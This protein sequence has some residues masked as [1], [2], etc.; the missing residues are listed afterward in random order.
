MDG[1]HKGKAQKNQTI[2]GNIQLIAGQNS[3]A[4]LLMGTNKALNIDGP[5]VYS[6]DDLK[7]LCIKNQTSLTSQY[8]KYIANSIIKKEEPK[9]A[10]VIKGAVYRTK[11]AME[12]VNMIL[13]ADSSVIDSD[14]IH[15]LWNKPDEN[16]PLFL[17]IYENGVKE[18]YRN[19]FS[20]TSTTLN[21][22]LFKPQTIYFWLVSKNAVPGNDEIHSSF[23][24][25]E[26]QWKTQLLDHYGQIMKEL[27]DA[28]IETERKLYDGKHQ[29]NPMPKKRNK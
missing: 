5:G 3:S 9:T 26:K 16:E 18:I 17:V 20:A 27:E 28:N 12:R 29:S 24:I 22:S 11:T 10:M 19:Q 25:G 13:P 21:T 8:I 4:V 6:F 23:V 7:A 2:L 14:S 15:F 1:S